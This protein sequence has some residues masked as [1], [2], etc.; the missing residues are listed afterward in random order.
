M[1][2]RILALLLILA[3]SSCSVHQVQERDAALKTVLQ[4][5][6]ITTNQAVVVSNQSWESTTAQLQRYQRQPANHNKAIT[7]R[8]YKVGEAMLVQLGRSGLAWGAGLHQLPNKALIKKEGDGNAPAGIFAFGTAFGYGNRP[9]GI[10]LPY[11]KAD[12]HD[13][14][15]D[16]VQS[17]DYNQWRRFVSHQADGAKQQWQSFERMRRDDHLYELGLEVM[18]NK[19]PVVAGQGSAI[20]L[21]IW[22]TPETPTAGCTAMA[23]ANLLTVLRWL[24]PKQQPLLVQMPQQGMKKVK[25]S[26]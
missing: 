6:P 12:A 3:L 5:L 24:D 22:K 14:Y 2:I 1:V 18:H 7:S 16:D 15:I 13:Y 20:F 11:R 10:Q 23:K 25:F 9:L 19:S 8:W 26:P 4:Q 17:A 21:H